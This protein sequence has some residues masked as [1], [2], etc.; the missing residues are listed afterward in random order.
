MAYAVIMRRP[1]FERTRS[2]AAVIERAAI[3]A[4]SPGALRDALEEMLREVGDREKGDGD[5]EDGGGGGNAGNALAPRSH[6][7]MHSRCLRRTRLGEAKKGLQELQPADVV[8]PSKPE[9]QKK[10]ADT[11]Q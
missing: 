5:G 8:D 9:N 10:Y 7:S 2:D 4:S 1:R 11:L 3:A 6:A